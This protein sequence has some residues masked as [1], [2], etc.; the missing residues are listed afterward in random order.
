LVNKYPS[1]LG[2]DIYSYE[3]C[4][5]GIPL[6]FYVMYHIER[7]RDV[8]KNVYKQQETKIWDMELPKIS[9]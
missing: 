2:K 6:R 1:D 9:T 5:V 4:N 7:E 3:N 8:M